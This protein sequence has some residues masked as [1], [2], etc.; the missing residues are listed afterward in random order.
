[1]TTFHQRVPRERSQNLRFRRFVLR[2]CRED[3]R[4]RKAVLHACSED[5]LFFVNVFVWQYNPNADGRHSVHIGPF[6][7]WPE[8]EEAALEILKAND[9]RNDVF[10]EKS[11][12]MGASWLLLMICVW[13]FL[14]RDMQKFL[15]ISRNEDAVDKPGDSD[16]LFWKIDFILRHL[17]EW[18]ASTDRTTGDGRNKRVTKGTVSRKSMSFE[19]RANGSMITG[20]A[21]TEKMGVGGRANM[22]ILDEFSQVP[23]AYEIYDRT[24]NTSGC[25][26]FNG[27]HKGTGTCFFHLSQKAGTVPNLKKI[28]M[29]W[30]GHADKRAGL[31]RF[32]RVT[33]RVEYLDPDY[34]YPRDFAPVC[35]GTPTGGPFPGLRSPWYDDHCHRKSG[36]GIAAD[37]DI[38]PSGSVEQLFDAVMIA[39]LINAYCKPPRHTCDLEWFKA[40]AEPVRLHNHAGGLIHIWDRLPNDGVPTPRRAVFCADIA[41]GNGKATASCLSGVDA[42][43]G[44]KFLEY[45]NPSIEPKDFAYLAVALCRLFK[46]ADGR[47]AKIGWESGGPGETFAKHVIELRHPD[48]FR[49]STDHKLNKRISDTPGWNNS[50]ESM[51]SLITNYRDA[52]RSRKFLNPSAAAL[53]ECLAFVFAPTG[54][55]KHTSA[56]N[57]ADNSSARVN[58]GDRTIADALCWKLID[59]MKQLVAPPPEGQPKGPT[60]NPYHVGSLAGRRQLAMMGRNDGWG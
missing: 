28:V 24:S 34:V 8:Q 43:T 30:T 42:E 35:D 54:F 12:E 37:V 38:N 9:D 26:V 58:H 44:E 21:T 14:F 60:P 56:D 10:I 19:N 5:F 53:T 46:S 40:D 49:R 52:L 55:I 32:D 27:T 6:I 47:V 22:M 59:E 31:Y 17:P 15:V 7:T 1:M 36:R 23:N 45:A 29:H 48:M 25:R 3:T 41:A 16:C 2:K 51:Y 4:Y 33:Q 11:R 50:P 13:L 57:K 20:Q 18:V 39:D